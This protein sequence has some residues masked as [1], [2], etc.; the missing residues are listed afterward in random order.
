MTFSS[1][2]LF[3]LAQGSFSVVCILHKPK[4]FQELPAREAFEL[5]EVLR[6]P[7]A[8][9]Q[10]RRLRGESPRLLGESRRGG[11][12]HCTRLST[13]LTK[14]RRYMCSNLPG[15]AAREPAERRSTQLLSKCGLKAVGGDSWCCRKLQLVLG[16]RASS[17]M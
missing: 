10:S 3:T 14:P 8:A 9:Q 15:Q 1:C 11:R 2:G 13:R 4:V 17:I 12:V 5:L 7:S 6:R 16:G